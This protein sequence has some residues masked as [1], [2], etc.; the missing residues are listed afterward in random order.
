MDTRISKKLSIFDEIAGDIISYT[1]AYGLKFF[2]RA[3]FFSPGFLVLLNYRFYS[4]LYGR[5]STK[6]LGR[7]LWRLNIIFS[8]CHIS[9]KSTL[10]VGVLLPHP[11]A[12]VIGDGV[13]V[14]DNC[15]IYQSVTIG[16]SRKDKL[17]YPELMSNCI[18]YAN[19][20]VVGKIVLSPGTVVPAC[21]FISERNFNDY[22]KK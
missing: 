16:A 11:V 5:A 1:G 3:I 7:I 14:G 10:G 19:S 9:P 18:V 4:R 6:I 17:T 8:G 13:I 22:S 12:V 20:V 21:S 2:L 15:T